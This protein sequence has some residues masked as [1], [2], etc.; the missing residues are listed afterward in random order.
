MSGNQFEYMIAD[1]YAPTK[2]IPER[3][4]IKVILKH[5]WAIF[6]CIGSSAK[7]ILG[8]NEKIFSEWLPNCKDYEIA[9]EYNIEIYEAPTNYPKGIEDDKYYSEIWNPIKK[10]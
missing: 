2:E 3:F 1:N 9:E 6:A 7:V 5:T 10:K 4:T 8:I